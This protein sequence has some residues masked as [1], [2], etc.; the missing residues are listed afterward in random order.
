M[1]AVVVNA[2]NANC[3]TGPQGLLDNRAVCARTAEL[4]GCPAEEV[5]FLS[6]GV[7][8]APLPTERILGALP[9]LVDDA[10]SEGGADFARAIMTTDLVPKFE[11]EVIGDSSVVGIAKGSGMIHPDMATMFGFLL[12]DGVLGSEADRDPHDA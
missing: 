9:A 8:G 6:T 2:G 1:R 10:S 5:L 3:S 11:T 7:I 12:T 4:L